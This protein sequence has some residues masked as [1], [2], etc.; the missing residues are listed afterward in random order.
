MLKLDTSSTCGRRKEEMARTG[1]PAAPAQRPI[2][3]IPCVRWSQNPP[4]R[5]SFWFCPFTRSSMVPASSGS[6]ALAAPAVPLRSGSDALVSFKRRR[7][8]EVARLSNALVDGGAQ[9]CTRPHS[10]GAMA[11]RL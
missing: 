6:T 2:R 11:Q 1:D 5:C 8:G 3:R 9:A 7:C 4:L 10:V